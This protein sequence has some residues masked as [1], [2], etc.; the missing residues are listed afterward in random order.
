MRKICTPIFGIAV[1][2]QFQ[3]GPVRMRSITLI[4]T[5]H[6]NHINRRFD[7]SL[8]SSDFGKALRALDEKTI[9]REF[10][11]GPLPPLNPDDPIFLKPQPVPWYLDRIGRELFKD[12]K[13]RYKLQVKACDGF[14]YI[15]L[16]I[17][18]KVGKK[19]IWQLLISPFFQEMTH[20]DDLETR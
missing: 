18:K 9:G 1:N 2:C 14:L 11:G 15:R 12:Q 4:L 10:S 19:S 6:K 20:S 16:K 7:K 8:I 17:L 13:Q 5:R 3:I